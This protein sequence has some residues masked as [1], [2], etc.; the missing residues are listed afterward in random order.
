MHI[1]LHNNLFRVMMA[2]R[3][4]QPTPI[5]IMNEMKSLTHEQLFFIIRMM[6]D[7]F[8]LKRLDPFSYKLFIDD[9][10]SIEFSLFFFKGNDGERGEPGLIGPRG[11]LVWQIHSILTKLNI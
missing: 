9:L 8:C 6:N 11:Y 10:H 7:N 1:R 2:S 4:T 3:V 5:I